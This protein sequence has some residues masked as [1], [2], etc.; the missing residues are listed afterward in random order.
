MTTVL[1]PPTKWSGFTTNDVKSADEFAA[2]LSDLYALGYTG[3]VVVV[4]ATS[5]SGQ[6]VAVAGYDKGPVPVPVP[7]PVGAHAPM[8]THAVPQSQPSTGWRK[9]RWA[10]QNPTPA[11]HS[12]GGVK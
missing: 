4:T 5:H 1:G 10:G 3:P 8:P 12:I 6:W 11:S 7:V 2:K 9:K